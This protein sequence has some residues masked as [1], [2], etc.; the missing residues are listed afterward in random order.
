MILMGTDSLKSW[1]Q[2]I[3]TITLTVSSFP[4]IYYKEM[5]GLRPSVFIY[6]IGR[7]YYTFSSHIKSA[8]IA[9]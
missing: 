8:N 2:S 6:L 4:I 3:H 7:L 9:G 5:G 1:C